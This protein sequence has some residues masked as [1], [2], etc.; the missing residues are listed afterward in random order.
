MH[1][2]LTTLFGMY[3]VV[4]FNTLKSILPKSYIRD[5]PVPHDVF[6]KPKSPG[7]KTINSAHNDLRECPGL[8]AIQ[9]WS[10]CMKQSMLVTLNRS[11][12]TFKRLS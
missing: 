3:F 1:F 9:L 4:A 7:I 11:S 10:L 2:H 6:L 5:A 8:S 12:M